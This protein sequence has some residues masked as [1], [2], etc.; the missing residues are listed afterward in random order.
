MP[1]AQFAL[2]KQLKFRFAFM[3]AITILKPKCRNFDTCGNRT[4]ST[5]STLCA[6]C[7]HA[8]A[9]LAGSRSSGNSHGS[10]GN[11]GNCLGRGAP[12]NAGN[13][14]GAPGNAGNRLGRGA[15]GNAGNTSTGVHKR[16]SG[17]RSGIKRST[18]T[19]LMVRQS[20]LDLI[21]TGQK[22][23][24]IRG[25][26]TQHR[27]WIHL[28]QCKS[29]MIQGRARIVDCVRLE[30]D[31]LM[32]YGEWHCL[33]SAD[34]VQYK[35]IWAWVLEQPEKFEVPYKYNHKPGAVIFVKVRRSMGP[36]PKR[37]RM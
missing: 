22:R 34:D 6:P 5:R 17:P 32:Q 29:G 7:F 12:G 26:A 23:W 8:R 16:A 20:W 1:S 13:S 36:A 24:E 9:R 21:L 30:R 25:R 2:F 37:G 31:S 28:V 4:L 11:V 27:G 33:Q 18:D 14:R 15:P 3:A 19:A 35:T 10:P